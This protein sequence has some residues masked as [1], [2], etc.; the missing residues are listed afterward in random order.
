MYHSSPSSPTQVRSSA[1]SQKLSE[2]KQFMASNN[3]SQ[4]QP[5]NQA[6]TAVPNQNASVINNIHRNEPQ[7]G[8]AVSDQYSRNANL[9]NSTDRNMPDANFPGQTEL[10]MDQT[11]GDY[12]EMQTELFMDQTGGDYPEMLTE[13]FMDQTG[14]DYPEMGSS[15]WDYQADI[16]Q[17][18]SSDHNFSS[19]M[20]LFFNQTGWD[21]PEMGS[22]NWDYQADIHQPSSSDHRLFS[23]AAGQLQPLQKAGQP[24]NPPSNRMQMLPPEV[25]QQQP[26]PPSMQVDGS[27][28]MLSYPSD[29]AGQQLLPCPP[30][31]PGQVGPGGQP[32][33]ATEVVSDKQLVKHLQKEVA[34]LEAELRTPDPSSRSDPNVEWREKDIKIKQMEMEI[35]ELKRQRD[36]AQHQV[37]ELRKKVQDEQ[38]APG[39]L[40]PLQNAAQPINP[41]S[42]RMQMLPPRVSQQQPRPPSMQVDGSPWMLSYPS[43]VAGQQLLPCPPPPPPPPPPLPGQVG[44]GGQ[45]PF[46]TQDDRI[47]LFQNQVLASVFRFRIEEDVAERFFPNIVAG[48][49]KMV[50]IVDTEGKSWSMNYTLENGRYLLTAGWWDF[51]TAHNLNESDIVRFSI[52]RNGNLFVECLP[53]K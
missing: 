42:N 12:P 28:W 50:T 37:E 19:Q 3:P 13:L 34:R 40:Q 32:P 43:D 26:R 4:P 6:T 9:I 10:F 38:P 44:P 47:Y 33:F 51:R 11:G 2:S 23:Q 53:G 27:P 24:I 39:Q 45:P 41:P 21:C 7:P 31:L 22:S 15:N 1:N 49:V 36:L 52:D 17:P 30:P 48:E 16:H 35:E 20:E 25:S 5:R 18:S 14:G 29:V 46:A 8:A